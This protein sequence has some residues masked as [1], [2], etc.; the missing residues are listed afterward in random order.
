MGIF[1]GMKRIFN[2][3]IFIAIAG[4]L[5]VYRAPVQQVIATMITEV[6]LV[7]KPCSSPLTYRLGSV[8]TRFGISEEDFLSAI[9][10]AEAIWE[11]PTGKELFSLDLKGELKINLVYDYRQEATEK[12]KSLGIA[13]DATK[14]N[15]DHLSEKYKE[16]KAD[17]A[18]LKVT[19]DARYAVFIKRKNAYDNTVALW[20]TKGGA[21]RQE[22]QRLEQERIALQV[23][24]RDIE[25]LQE[26]GNGYVSEINALVVVLNSLARSLNL[27][28]DAFNDTVVTR[29][30]EFEEGL[31]TSNSLGQKIDIFEFNN[32][33]KLVRVLAHE[34]GHALG[35][36]HVD[37]AEAIMYSVNQS[38]NE[39]LTAADIA[40]LKST[41]RFE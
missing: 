7:F 39:V 27:E 25:A 9:A 17:Y 34:F 8:D 1:S 26:K 10:E 16:L 29:G 20:N 11:K 3:I 23:E 18:E 19:Y 33:D 38:K 40:E 37:D 28:V 30:K 24:A 21:P 35:L 32:R 4:A 31:Y 6:K 15:Y 41:C 22:Y 14:T 36:D 13:V 2:L 12:L 5:Y